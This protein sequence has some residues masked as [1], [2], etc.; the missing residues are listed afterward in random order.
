M[1]LK[2]NCEKCQ[3]AL[4]K[5]GLAFICSCECT[6]CEDCAREMKLVCPNCKGELVRR[7]KR[8]SDSADN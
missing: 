7:P 1:L 5:D 4:P 6:W 8:K 2:P 3:K